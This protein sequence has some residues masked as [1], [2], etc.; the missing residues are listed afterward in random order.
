MAEKTYLAGKDLALEET[1]HIFA[2]KLADMG[3]HIIEKRW[4]NPAPNLYSVHLCDRDCPQIFAN[5]KGLC[6]QAALASG[7]GELLERLSTGYLWADFRLQAV[8]A[9]FGFVHHPKERWFQQEELQASLPDALLDTNLQRRYLNADCSL[10]E[11]IDLNAGAL[12]KGVCTLPYVRQ[13]DQKICYI[14]V[15]L[16]ANLFVSNGMSAGNTMSEALVQG[17]SE[18]FERAIKQYV[19]TQ[20][21]SLP[22]VPHQILAQLPKIQQGLDSL[23]QAGFRVLALDASLGGQYPVMAV[24]LQHPNGGLYA[25]FGAHPNFDVALERA[26]TELVQGRSLN[27]LD[28]FPA[29]T[30]NMEQVCDTHNLELHFIDSSGYLSWALLSND[31]DYAFYDWQKNPM[32]SLD[33]NQSATQMMAYLKQQGFE[34]YV[35]A[36]TQ[37]GVSACRILVPGFSDIYP[38]DELYLNN[39]N[40]SLKVS[41]LLFNLPH[42]KAKELQHLLDYLEETGLNDQLKLSEWAGFLIHKQSAW[43]RLRVG[44]LKMRLNLALNKAD[45]ALFEL[46]NL[47]NSQ[48][49]STQEKAEYSCL[50]AVLE[51]HALG[52]Q[53]KELQAYLDALTF[54]YDS[55]MLHSAMAQVNQQQVFSKYPALDDLRP[56][57][58]Q[59]T[60]INA[61]AKVLNYAKHCSDT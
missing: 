30:A 18:I 32:F 43:G 5:G 47:L 2:Q 52:Y 9:E 1:L 44:E 33:N 19:I 17:L 11:L 35:F 51:L 16:I 60:L 22:Q 24:L 49:L 42:L 23:N 48:Q 41:S 45:D 7:Y 28:E 46:Q 38:A 10:N 29:P 50:K 59:Q 36:Y 21:I 6:Q 61:Y 57:Q 27:E 25:S 3:F 31:A 4:L 12:N 39:N 14:P 15:N 26:L 53:E 34:S 56:S 58:E 37:L 55:D 13:S 8:Y 40:Q 54:Y 20:A